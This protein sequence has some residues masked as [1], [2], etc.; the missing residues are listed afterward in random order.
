MKFLTIFLFILATVVSPF[1]AHTVEENC[2]VRIAQLGM[3]GG[4]LGYGRNLDYEQF[5][6]FN[7][8]LMLSD[9]VGDTFG[10]ANQADNIEGAFSIGERLASRFPEKNI[11][12]TDFNIKG[13]TR[14]GNLTQQNLDN[15]ADS[16]PSLEDGAFDLVVLRKGMCTCCNHKP[17]GGFS[18]KH[19]ATKTF[20]SNV[21]S[22]LNLN[23]PNAV[24]ILHGQ[25]MLKEKTVQRWI[26]VAKELEVEFP[27]EFTFARAPHGVGFEAHD[28]GIDALPKMLND[29][30]DADDTPIMGEF[31]SIFIRPKNTP[32]FKA[33]L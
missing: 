24:A 31:N 9:G 29:V 4:Q 1:Q 22:K 8:I 12:Q 6:S 26:H 13:V 25:E 11:V 28:H 10:R 30:H 3:L 5:K 17:C 15:S 21:I 7:S 16:W 27:V 33:A 32:E 20:F 14:K 19:Q 18:S 2:I 23:N